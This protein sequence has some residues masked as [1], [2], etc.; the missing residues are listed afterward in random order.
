MISSAIIAVA[1]VNFVQL[2]LAHNISDF[3][4]AA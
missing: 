2:S 3:L 4:L 1:A